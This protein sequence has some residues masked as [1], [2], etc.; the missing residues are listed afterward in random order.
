M[1][2]SIAIVGMAC[3]YP[4]ARNPHELWENVLAQ[5]RAFRRLPPE[6]LRLE[7]YFSNDS[8]VPDAIYAGEVAVIEG[9]EFNRV[10]FRIAGPIFRSVDLT[11]WIAL[12]VADQALND[13]GFRDGHGLPLETK[14]VLVG[15]TF[16]GE[17][18]LADTLRLRWPLV[19]RV[20][21]A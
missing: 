4:D 12:D 6:R 10:R 19:R 13:A 1:S 17:F 15:N 16:T 2:S 5:R 11:H 20:V 9:Y 14:G 8:S 3:C 21:E 18:S 7:D